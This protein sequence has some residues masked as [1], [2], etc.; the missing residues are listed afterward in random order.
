[1]N[2]EEIINTIKLLYDY[3]TLEEKM[4][5]NKNNDTMHKDTKYYILNP[6]WLKN[7]KESINYESNKA[8]LKKNITGNQEINL[9]INNIKKD[10]YKN[11]N[12][13]CLTPI[14]NISLNTN[15][16]PNIS[17]VR[18]DCFKNLKKYKN[19]QF[20]SKKVIFGNNNIIIQIEYNIYEFYEKKNNIFIPN[21]LVIFNNEE[22]SDNNTYYNKLFHYK[23]LSDFFFL[24]KISV[25][26]NIKEKDI[27]TLTKESVIIGKMLLI[28]KNFKYSNNK[29]TNLPSYDNYIYS[30][31]E[32]Y[33]RKSEDFD[34]TNKYLQVMLDNTIDQN[35]KEIKQK[36]EKI[37]KL[38]KDISK[39]SQQL[40][41]IENQNQ[42]LKV[43]DNQNQSKIKELSDLNKQAEIEIKQL[44]EKNI[45]LE[46]DIKILQNKII[47]LQNKVKFDLLSEFQKA[48]QIGLVNIGSTCY[49]NATLQCFSQTISLTEYFL[50]PKNKD[51]II[52]GKFN[53]DR[54]N[55]RLANTYYEVVTNLWK[56]EELNGIKYFEPRKFKTV[57]GNLN[58]LFEK[59][60]A[61]DAKDMIVFFLEQIHKEINLVNPPKI[62]NTNSNL[63][64]YNR[65]IMLSHF[66]D[67]FKSNNKSIIS[68]NFF[69]VVETTQKC[70]N[71]QNN[72]IPNF[73]CYNY[74][75]QNCFIFPLEEVRKFRNER[76]LKAIQFNQMMISMGQITPFMGTNLNV[77]T[78]DN[79]V[80]LDD[81]FEYNQ[82]DE[83]MYG[84]NRIFCNLCKQNSESIYG[85][86]I[87]TLPNILIMIL[88]RGKA[89]IY[90]VNLN[91]TQEINISNYVLN[92]NE[93]YIY[94]IYGVITHLGQSG[95]SGHFVASC[96]SQVDN[97][98]YR[99]NDSMV[100]IINDF[101]SEILNFGS[102][103]ILFYERKK[104]NFK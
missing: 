59:M 62:I 43:K 42:A 3:E 57:L 93:P 51:I 30:E 49:M 23:S 91:F 32:K 66:I 16:Y 28:N 50:D 67:E 2:S 39:L 65:E 70:Q 84:E 11:L 48:P 41:N 54:Q 31:Y 73:I 15:Y 5:N 35:N 90:N 81:C 17:I 40:K 4:L 24:E 88:N 75:I 19:Y 61:S 53:N 20:I 64:Q 14:L 77:N 38:S 10:F 29:N 1:M 36:N 55:L 56:K 69:I 26:N 12:E 74:N 71:C 72:N 44:K 34:Q 18:N 6:Q 45:Q 92:A 25:N 37:E 103:Y 83:L 7:L 21:C 9:N 22:K 85:N 8:L 33:K 80:T 63:N 104:N 98:W 101:N 94:S 86:K 46:N 100:S 95:E 96:K 89:N 52:K 58:N 13:S 82:K 87:L 79:V 27:H 99:Y 76:L 102:P 97:K 47:G 68:D 60:E 78:N